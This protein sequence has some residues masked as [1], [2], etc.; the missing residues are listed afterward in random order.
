SLGKPKQQVV[1]HLA[2]GSMSEP[3]HARYFEMQI[4]VMARTQIRNLPILVLDQMAIEL[5]IL[6]REC[7]GYLPRPVDNHI[8]E[9]SPELQRHLRIEGFR[10]FPLNRFARAY[11]KVHMRY[12]L[13]QNFD[14]R[15]APQ[16]SWP[17][18]H[19]M[20]YPGWRVSD[21]GAT[22]PPGLPFRCGSVDG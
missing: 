3:H 22:P 6:S 18:R 20:G 2:C 16:D 9:F 10:H 17:I 11:V 13:Q 15:K 7:C 14:L 19:P 12:F 8:S 5:R 4:N 21:R 1:H